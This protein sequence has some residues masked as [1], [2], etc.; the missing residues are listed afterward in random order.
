[1]S[2]KAVAGK[3]EWFKRAMTIAIISFT[4][5]AHAQATADAAAGN[6]YLFGGKCASQGSWTAEALNRTREIMEVARRLQQDPKCN[7]LAKGLMESI[8]QLTTTLGQAA[9]AEGPV[10]K[11]QRLLQ[12]M[13]AFSQFKSMSSEDRIDVTRALLQRA[14]G[15]ASETSKVMTPANPSLPQNQ[16]VVEAF[17]SFTQRAHATA[18]EGMNVFNSMIKQLS[19]NTECPLNNNS[20]GQL[21]AA[22]VQILSAFAG[23]GQSYTG[24]KLTE[25]ISNLF[26]AFRD[27]GYADIIRAGNE[28]TLTN[29]ISCLLE[30]NAES[31]CSARDARQLYE[32]SRKLTQ[33]RLSEGDPSN[34]KSRVLYL[35]EKAAADANTGTP[36]QGFF[37]LT[38]QM[39]VITDWLLKVMIAV[40]PQLTTDGEFRNQTLD[41][42]NNFQKQVNTLKATMNNRVKTIRSYSDPEVI[43]NSTIALIM[44]ISGNLTGGGSGFNRDSSK[45]NFFMQSLTEIDIPFMLAGIDT[46]RAVIAQQ[47]GLFNPEQWL[48]NNKKVLPTLQN[49]LALLDSMGANLDRVIGVAQTS[50]ITFYNQW[51][52]V[53]K[54]NVVDSSLL[55]V[56]YNVPEILGQIHQYLEGLRGRLTVVIEKERLSAPARPIDPAIIGSIVDTQV[57]IRKILAQFEDIRQKS[58]RLAEVRAMSP[59]SPELAAAIE[60]YG[61]SGKDFLQ[62]LND[63]LNIL[64]SRTGFLSNRMATYVQYDF[65][66]ALRDNLNSGK[67]FS[68]P[69]FSQDLKYAANVA[70]YNQMLAVTGDNPATVRQDI[71][72]ALNISK[73]NLKMTEDLFARYLANRIAELK[74]RADPSKPAAGNFSKA[75]QSYGRLFKEQLGTVPTEGRAGW[76]KALDKITGSL[77]VLKEL[78]NP[79]GNNY[80]TEGNGYR[81]VFNSKT[82]LPTDNEF[83][84]A[85]EMLQQYCIQALAFSELRPVWNLCKGAKLVSPYLVDDD[86][87]TKDAFDKY[88]NVDFV[89]RAT[90]DFE[91]DR[92]VNESNRIC[93]LRDYYRRNAV[94]YMTRGLQPDAQRNL[95]F[96][97]KSELTLKR[98]DEAKRATDAAER[99]AAQQKLV[100]EQ[101]RLDALKPKEPQAPDDAPPVP[102]EPAAPKKSN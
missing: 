68:D 56:N 13:M 93:A 23:S 92:R 66:A 82:Q 22:S 37:I 77:G 81:V 35:R 39:P 34:P 15:F 32:E 73:V 36:L 99:A 65:Q 28:A 10:S 29:S 45:V 67:L 83:G 52:I 53:D 94:I 5:A 102:H 50:A 72:N 59:S 44:E 74:L 54:Q 100:E 86:K 20:G 7:A 60:D 57:R 75:K 26:T 31:Y 88:L 6:P 91:K 69:Q 42:V 62:A 101:R 64:L 80:N 48:Q 8:P 12:D 17:S 98:E 30:I 71:S 78:F 19:D 11:S 51:A 18:N 49:P 95:R 47:G 16:S 63:Q 90:A 61:K 1:M 97:V 9:A 41:S 40:D 84:T 3:S 2:F 79:F 46:P 21:F 58:A 14:V 43:T 96:K 38:Q 87:E 85:S 4:S 24:S 70:A 89:E 27:K 33:V 55:G 76:Q 25:S